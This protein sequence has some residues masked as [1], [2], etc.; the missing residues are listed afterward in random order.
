MNEEG[1]SLKLWCNSY[2]SFPMEGTT[3]AQDARAKR[4]LHCWGNKTDSPDNISL[5]LLEDKNTLSKQGNGHDFSILFHTDGFYPVKVMT[6]S[7]PV[8]FLCVFVLFVFLCVFVLATKCASIHLHTCALM[9]ACKYTLELVWTHACMQVH[10]CKRVHVCMHAST[11]LHT[12][13]R[14]CARKCT[15]ARVSLHALVCALVQVPLS[16]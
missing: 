3:P 1:T 4:A 8:V 11:H 15:L 14:T 5:T 12:F 13:A 16:S 6:C 2:R 7:V 10:Y 9:C